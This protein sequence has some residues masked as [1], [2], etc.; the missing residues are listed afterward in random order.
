MKTSIAIALLSLAIAGVSGCGAV[1]VS[2]VSAEVPRA[3]GAKTEPKAAAKP[4]AA[5]SP[6]DAVYVAAASRNTAL[7]TSISWPFGGRTQRGWALHAQLIGHVVG[8]D[9][10]PSSPAFARAVAEWQKSQRATPADGVVTV[11]VWQRIMKILQSSRRLDA[12]Q[13]PVSELVEAPAELWYDRQR[14]A[15]NRMLRRDAFEAYQRMVAAARAD[16]GRDADGYFQI[17]SGHRSPEYQAMLRKNAGN[18]STAA[19]AVRSPHFTGRAIDIYVGGDPVSTADANRARQVETPAYRW[20]AYN[21]HSFGFRPYFYE[22]WHWEY[23]P[24]LAQ[25]GR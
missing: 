5:P 25:T 16:L 23:D 7:A 17:I 9:A 6:A 21:A 1:P 20:L 13:P 8:T 18:P 14:P 19:L 24:Q 11:E 10:D 2:N 12:T 4:A 15:A 22:P 3:M